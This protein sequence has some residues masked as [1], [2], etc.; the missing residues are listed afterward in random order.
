[1]YTSSQCYGLTMEG[2]VVLDTHFPFV[3]VSVTDKN[4]NNLWDVKK[5]VSSQTI[6]MHASVEHCCIINKSILFRAI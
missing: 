6:Q 5:T 4:L 3:V 2:G 1:M